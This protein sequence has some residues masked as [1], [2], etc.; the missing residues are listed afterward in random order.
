[1]SRK[2]LV[3]G[4]VAYK[5]R[6]FAE[7][8]DLFR[9]AAER[10]PEGET[11]EGRTAQL[12]LARTIHSRYIG[13]RQRQDWAE[14][15]IAEYQKMLAIDP[16]EQSSYK[17]V[18]GLYENLQRNDD[19]MKWVTDR[20]ANEGIEPHYRAEAYT[21]LAARQNTCANEI[22]GSDANRK[23]IQRDGKDVY[24]YVKPQN[25]QDLERLRSCVQ[26]GMQYTER[27]MA[28]ETDEVKNAASVNIQGSS[29]AELRAIQE[30]IKAFESARSY[31]A[32]MLIQASRL[33]EMDGNEA[34]ATR[35][36]DEAD[37]AR[38]NFLK[39]SEVSA[40]IQNELDARVA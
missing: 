36:R 13:D 20:A 11:L 40:A 18:A 8:E 39:L 25:P 3:D 4:S 29:D 38:E 12:F 28:L 5:E 22:S 33:A 24:Q 7:A 37:T 27:A 19:W 21:S 14:Q 16:N 32:S 10:D 26:Q 15:A 9:R 35:L 31:R 2:N 30:K 23:E 34:E 1:M 17:A 6:K